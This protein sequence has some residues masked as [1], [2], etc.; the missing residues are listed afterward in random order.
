VLA[1]VYIILAVLSLNPAF[2]VIMSQI[3]ALIGELVY[4]SHMVVLE[5]NYSLNL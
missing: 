4:V 3:L 2:N 5:L 1:A